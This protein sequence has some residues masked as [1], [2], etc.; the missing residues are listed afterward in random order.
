MPNSFIRSEPSYNNYYVNDQ[1]EKF[2][3]ESYFLPF[4]EKST[5]HTDNNNNYWHTGEKAVLLGNYV[6]DIMSVPP[7]EKIYNYEYIF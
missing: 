6:V 5:G 4:L 2:K 7:A 3:Y 1:L